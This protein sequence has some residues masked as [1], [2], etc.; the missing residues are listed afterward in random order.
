MIL[1]KLKKASANPVLHEARPLLVAI[2]IGLVLALTLTVAAAWRPDH[3]VPTQTTE[4][5][6]SI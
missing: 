4:T 2:T 6:G 5:S 3:P 1:T